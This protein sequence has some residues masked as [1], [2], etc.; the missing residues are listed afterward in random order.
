MKS[1]R[2]SVLVFLLMFSLACGLTGTA[3]NVPE[4]ASPTFTPPPASNLSQS[5]TMQ[6]M[7]FNETG[8]APVYTLTAQIPNLQ[9]SSDARVTTFNEYLSQI[10]LSQLDQYRKDVIAFASNP[11][12]TGGSSFDMQYS[13]IGQRADIWSI[14]F[15]ISYYTDGAAHPGNYSITLNYDL[16]NGRELTLDEL[17]ISNSNYLQVISDECKAQLTARDMAF[18]MFSAGADPLP[19]NYQH[20]NISSE[21]LIIS[22]DEYQV[23]PYA[24]GPQVV[25][26]PF[27]ALQSLINPQGAASLFIQ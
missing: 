5:L 9:G 11:P 25:T 18:D 24:A 1:N 8:T 2:L 4:I 20:W 15:E 7:P 6:S 16:Q 12:V 22:F 23:A 21:G 27:S 14:K 13:V 17:F 10:V 3:T 26:V 19:E